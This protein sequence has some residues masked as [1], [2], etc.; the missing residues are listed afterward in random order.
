MG[1]HG[2]YLISP[3]ERWRIYTALCREEKQYLQAKSGIKTPK[4]GGSVPEHLGIGIRY[5][6]IILDLKEKKIFEIFTWENYC[7]QGTTFT[8]IPN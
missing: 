3:G 6:Y 2:L 1:T 5:E 7:V 8:P 4:S